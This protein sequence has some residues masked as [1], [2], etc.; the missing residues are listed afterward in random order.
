MFA[1]F[2]DRGKGG[3]TPPTIDMMWGLREW[4][5]LDIPVKAEI[6]MITI[7]TVMPGRQKW[8]NHSFWILADI[9]GRWPL[10]GLVMW[11]SAKPNEQDQH[12]ATVML[13]W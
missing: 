2:E 12:D 8:K 11:L 9:L 10:A 13:A 4:M 7:Q 3:Q 5:S 6:Q 1:W